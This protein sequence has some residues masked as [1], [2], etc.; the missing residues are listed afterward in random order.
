MEIGLFRTLNNLEFSLAMEN[1]VMS[2]ILDDGQ[3]PADAAAQ[4]LAANPDTLD[5]WLDGVSTLSGEP[6]LGAVQDSLGL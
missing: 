5:V 6:A 3:E 2:A 4:W 1:E